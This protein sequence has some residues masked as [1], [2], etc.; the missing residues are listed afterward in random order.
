[1]FS[2]I[3][4][5][6]FLPSGHVTRYTK[7]LLYSIPFSE[8]YVVLSLATSISSRFL[9]L[10]NVSLYI[11]F[12]VLG[13]IIFFSVSAPPKHSVYNPITFFPLILVGIGA[14]VGMIGS[15]RAVRK[16]LKI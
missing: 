8:V 5:S 2:F 6:P 15:A 12:T 14:L 7:S 10:K 16:Y 3:L 11:E 13:I 4:T 1:M 9:Q